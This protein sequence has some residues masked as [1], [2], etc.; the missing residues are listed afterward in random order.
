[1]TEP[2]NKILIVEDERPLRRLL[3]ATLVSHGYAAIEAADAREAI[4]MATQHNPDLVLLD[5]GLPDRD[6]LEVTKE[7]R[8]WSS[9]P[10]IVLSARGRESDKVEALDQGADDYLTKP[11]GMEE[12]LA[13]VRVALR[14]SSG[15]DPSE[16]NEIA[17]GPLKVDLAS[18]E[19][20]VRGELVHLTPIE[21]RLLVL[22][23]KNAGRVMTHRQILHD[24][25]GPQ[26]ENQTHYLRVYMTHLRRKLEVDPARPQL[27]L[28]E[29][30][31]GY[32][33]R[34]LDPET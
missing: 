16:S 27:L 19:V 26:T 18:H 5:L 11:F 4:A 3:R 10:I 24:V 13:R 12:L 2:R 14:R 31:V 17:V 22:L 25:W 30:G 23:A 29:P 21:F 6:G 20:R 15:R 7:M 33:M 8:E 32:R 34:A 1:V 28:N 9:A